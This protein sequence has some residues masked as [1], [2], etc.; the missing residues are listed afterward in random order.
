MKNLYAIKCNLEALQKAIKEAGSMK[1]LAKKVGVS[2]QTVLNW[3]SERSSISLHN[4][5]R[6]EEATEGKITRKEILP[7]YPW[8]SL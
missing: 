6:I 4:C 3:T 7:D 2:Y 5:I 1:D 8:D